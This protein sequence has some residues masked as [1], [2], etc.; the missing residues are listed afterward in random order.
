MDFRTY[1]KKIFYI[2]TPIILLASCGLIGGDKEVEVSESSVLSGPPL[3]IPPEFDVDAQ[4]QNQ[5]IPNYDLETLEPSQN[6]GNF[7]NETNYETTQNENIFGEETAPLETTPLI[8]DSGE[9]QSFESYNP[10]VV[11]QSTPLNTNITPRVKR[12]YTPTVPSD[13]YNFDTDLA[14]KTKKRVYVQKKEENFEPFG[15]TNSLQE[16]YKKNESLSKEEE[17]LLEDILNTDDTKSDIQDFSVKG[18]SD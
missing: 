16:N 5:T 17:V 1:I 2:A 9:I 15:E 13:S 11:R 7:E 4:N 6:P 8:N 12:K 18:D 3:A 10:N 14:P